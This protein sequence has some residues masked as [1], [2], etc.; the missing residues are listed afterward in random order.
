M[1][2]VIRKL[3]LIFLS[4]FI[5]LPIGVNASEVVDIHLFYS[6]SCS[7][8]K[9]EKEYL[10]KLLESDK[11][12]KIHLYR[13]NEI[14]DYE[15]VEL[16]DKVQ[17]ILNTK[18]GYIPYT[19]IGSQHIVGFANYTKANIE[20]AISSCREEGCYDIVSGIKD[21]KITKENIDEYM[22][23]DDESDKKN[24]TETV[25]ILG[26]IDPKDVSLPLLAII[27]GLVDGF[28]P[29]AMWVL[30][31]L[32]SMLLGMKDRK[33]MM[34]LGSLF[35]VASASVYLLFMV[36]WLNIVI[37]VTSVKWVQ[38]L[39]AVVALIGGLINIRSYIKSIGQD[40]GCTVVDD[41]KRKKIFGKIKK[42]TSE[43]SLFLA[44]VGVVLLAI[45]V[46]VVEL[47]CSAGLPVLFTNILAI[48]EVGTNLSSIYILIY[49]FFFM[50]DDLIVF[51]VAMFTLKV[52]GVTTKY[53][54]YTHL[55]GGI[56]MLLIGILLILKPEWIMFNF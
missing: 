49:I 22:T 27:M 5:F 50:L 51:N 41:N 8:C 1:N 24:D 45:S 4:I 54:K 47:A 30:L 18:K 12:I 42:F 53:T 55:I 35:I 46:N 31:F 19:V 43:K 38:I 52:T 40:S 34:Y 3:L 29:C 25:P 26:E 48:N 33:K 56:I 13:V 39:I 15:N 11:N 17:D 10:N 7:H 6:S 37:N 36:A 23:E 28:N 16:W 32:I 44:S 14:D 21:G 20:K 9:N 2:K